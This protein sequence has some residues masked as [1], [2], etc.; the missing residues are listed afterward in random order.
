MEKDTI[1]YDKDA[2]EKAVNCG[3]TSF[4]H[5]PLWGHLTHTPLP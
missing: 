1:F 2:E 5:T 3:D 4:P